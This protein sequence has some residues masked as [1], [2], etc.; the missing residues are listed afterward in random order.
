MEDWSQDT[1]GPG[2]MLPE[3]HLRSQ[4]GG[5]RANDAEDGR[6]VE[7]KT[8]ILSLS[9]NHRRVFILFRKFSLGI[10]FLQVH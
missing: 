10:F 1:V 7:T 4:R 9:G 8:V 6:L 3:S 2:P 5:E